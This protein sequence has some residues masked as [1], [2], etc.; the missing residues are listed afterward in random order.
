MQPEEIGKQKGKGTERRMTKNA[1]KTALQRI[2]LEMRY[3]GWE[4]A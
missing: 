1:G 3:R 4:K 2:L